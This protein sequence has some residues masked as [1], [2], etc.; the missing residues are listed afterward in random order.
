MTDNQ[1]TYI[2]ERDY[3]EGRNEEYAYVS[4]AFTGIVRLSHEKRFIQKKFILNEELTLEKTRIKGEYVLRS[5]ASN[6]L[7]LKVILTQDSHEIDS[8]VI[9]NFNGQTPS[10]NSVSFRNYEFIKLLEF[11]DKIKFIDLTNKDKFRIRVGE[12][13]TSK[14]LIDKQDGLIIDALK[15]IEGSE[16]QTLLETLA[17]DQ[18]TKEDLDILTGRKKG[19]EEFRINLF[20]QSNWNEKN[21][22]NFF[23]KNTW[24]FGYGLDYRF[25]CIL[26]KEA[27]IS[28]IDLDSKNSVIADFLLGSTKF[29]VLV[30]LKRPDTPLFST[31]KNRS[32]SWALSHD[33]TNAVSQILSQKA[34]WE[35]KSK[36]QQFDEHGT[37]INQS[38]IDPKT[39]LVIGNSRQFSGTNKNDLI[40]LKTF[41]LYRRNSRNIDIV[42]YNELF[43]RAYYVVNQKQFDENDIA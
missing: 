15:K 42:T 10:P 39:I 29:T 1:D 11:L 4:K 26:Q 3:F 17:N 43:E 21:W 2:S 38:T 20:E 16:R 6:K 23:N 37:P 9:Q 31:D 5:S 40:K 12:I 24:I 30:E 36:A 7:Q 8:I 25:L 14:V 33:I 13:D 35:I 27:H 32:E 41:E 19:L 18:F 28:N 22:Q 34:E